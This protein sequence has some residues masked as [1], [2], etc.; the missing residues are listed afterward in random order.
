MTDVTGGG[1]DGKGHY[2]DS[3]LPWIR[4]DSKEMLVEM[5]ALTLRQAAIFQTVLD[6][7]AVNCGLC[8]DDDD[9]IMRYL[10]RGGG[11]AGCSTAEWHKTRDYLIS[12]DYLYRS[13]NRNLRS[14]FIDA[15]YKFAREKKVAPFRTIEGGKHV[16]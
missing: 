9:H 1:D 12:I 11:R 14:K 6:L 3:S 4:R 16:D 2:F 13:D 7:M 10:R 5:M 8:P 15:A